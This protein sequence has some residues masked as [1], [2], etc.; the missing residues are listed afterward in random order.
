[1]WTRSTLLPSLLT[2][3]F[4]SAATPAALAED[5]SLVAER[6]AFLR[7]RRGLMLALGVWGL[8]N[9]AGGTVL[10]AIDPLSNSPDPSRRAFRKSFGAMAATYGVINTAL[11]VAALAGTPSL[12]RGLNTPELVQE[13]RHRSFTVFAANA[14]LDVLY[15]TVGASLW[16]WG[17]SATARGTGAGFLSQG[18]FL[19]GFDTLGALVYRY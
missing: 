9:A 11:A 2:F 15:I 7:D 6:E 4:L 19:V 17:H 16:T 3:A 13:H 12:R 5:P 18:A 14:G 10:I 8:L 1:V